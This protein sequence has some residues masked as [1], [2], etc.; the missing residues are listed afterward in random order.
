MALLG[1]IDDLNYRII[2]LLEP[3]DIIVIMTLNKRT[4]KLVEQT[5]IYQDLIKLREARPKY[6]FGSD[7]IIKQYYWYGL[8]HVIKHYQ[9]THSKGIDLAAGNGHV[10]ILEWVIKQSGL[11]YTYSKWAIN[12]AAENG[13][14]DVLEWFLEWFIHSDLDFALMIG[15]YA[16]DRAA[17]NGHLHILEWFWKISFV[18]SEQAIDLASANGHVSVLEWFWWHDLQFRYS[19][20]GI[21]EASANGH[22]HILEWYKKNNT[23]VQS[24]NSRSYKRVYFNYTMAAV[25]MAAANGHVAVL[26][27]WENSGFPFKYSENAVDNAA[28]NGHVTVL[29]W[30]RLL[31]DRP[32]KTVKG[33]MSR[34]EFK[35]TIQAVELAIAHHRTD[36]ITWFRMNIDY[37][38]IMQKS[39]SRLD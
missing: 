20:C 39:Y 5:L 25:D 24:R 29:E 6:K 13:H 16:I 12:W 26:E 36:V 28:A 37:D 15:A 34:L 1:E 8:M 21:D 17:G 11:F 7:D 38:Q 27:W 18:Y 30:F 22:I 9:Y 32:V 4:A 14:I 3:K 35:Y 10:N 19:S 23:N 31:G 2:F 33:R